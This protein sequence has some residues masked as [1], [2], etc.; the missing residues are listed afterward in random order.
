MKT[1][2]IK[3]SK[4]QHLLLQLMDVLWILHSLNPENPTLA[5]VVVPGLKHTEQVVHALVEIVH[6]F[7]SCD[8]YSNITIAVYLQLLLC[9][10]TVIAFSAKQALCRVLKH[11]C[12][13]RRVYILPSPPRCSS[14]Q[15]SQYLFSYCFQHCLRNFSE[16]GTES[17]EEKPQASTQ[18]SQD[19]SGPSQARYEVDTVEA[20]PLLQE[21]GGSSSNNQ[22]VNP[23][24]ALLGGGSGF[25]Q[26][27]DIPSDAD[28][29][30]M[31]EL[32][33][34]LSLQ[35]HELGGESSQQA[36][37]GLQVC[38]SQVLLVRLMVFNTN[39]ACTVMLCLGI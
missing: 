16:P 6:A 18:S 28:D 21:G 34:A 19:E 20:I 31:V 8:T 12:R 25:P 29:E 24:E 36:M 37:H 32:A 23:L 4:N 2:S 27:L 15:G 11:K 3:G 7:N 22:N 26:I 38:D 39:I 13:R 17:E 30:T 1:T 35:E 14:A 5:P 9:E 33:I 10:D